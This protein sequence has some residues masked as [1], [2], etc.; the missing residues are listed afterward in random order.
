MKSRFYLELHAIAQFAI[1]ITVCHME[2]LTT[3]RTASHGWTERRCDMDMKEKRKQVLKELD[4]LES[5]IAVLTSRINATRYV[6]TMM[7]DE[8]FLEWVEKFGDLED[9]LI[10]IQLF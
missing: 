1:R 2:F 3:V 7:D 6:E 4:E 9:G 8:A 10:H 5:D